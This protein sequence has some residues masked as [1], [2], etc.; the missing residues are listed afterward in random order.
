M[1]KTN[2]HFSQG[3]AILKGNITR[4]KLT[5]DYILVQE[6]IAIFI[7]CLAFKQRALYAHMENALTAEK[8][9]KLSLLCYYLAKMKNFSDP[10][11]LWKFYH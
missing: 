7:F 1:Q 4:K 8:V 3:Q 6:H 11:F 9:L 10:L 2:L 5:G